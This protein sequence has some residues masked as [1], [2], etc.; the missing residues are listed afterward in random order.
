MKNLSVLVLAVAGFACGNRPVVIDKNISVAPKNAVAD[1]K[2]GVVKGVEL[3]KDERSAYD[4]FTGLIGGNRFYSS[5]KGKV[6]CSDTVSSRRKFLFD[7]K[8][9]F[10]VDKIFIIPLSSGKY[11]V[12]WQETD[13]EGVKTYFA[14]FPE[15]ATKPEWESVFKVPNPGQPVLDGNAIYVSSLGM[16]GKLNSDNGNFFWRHDSLYDQLHYAY[17]KF[18]P[19]LVHE[20]AIHFVDFPIEGRREIRDTLK[21]DPET[22]KFIR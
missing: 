2:P 3:N 19:A 20:H 17:Q 9:E 4:D 13:H 14:A 22:G 21:C 8:A 12:N 1:L 18:E 10:L 11:F 7:L 6:E 16:V 15:G 5:Y